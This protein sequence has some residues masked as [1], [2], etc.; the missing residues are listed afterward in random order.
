MT[1]FGWELQKILKRR[2]AR[3]ALLLVVVWSAA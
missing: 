2:S 1:L 3:L